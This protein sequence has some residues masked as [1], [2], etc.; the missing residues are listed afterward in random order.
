V[1]LV[2]CGNL[3]VVNAI[4]DTTNRKRRL[5]L[6]VIAAL[7]PLDIA[8]K[9]LSCYT[10]VEIAPSAELCSISKCR[11]VVFFVAYEYFGIL[12]GFSNI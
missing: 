11:I 4:E 9:R 6:E 1:E 5:L 8:T 2:V 10:S 3:V 7:E 12:T